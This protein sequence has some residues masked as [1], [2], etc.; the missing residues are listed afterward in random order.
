M[1]SIFRQQPKAFY[2][3]FMLEFWERF[4]FYSVNA[5]LAYFFV[6]QLGFSESVAFYTF[7]AFSALVYGLVALGGFVGDK[8]LGTKRTIV[9]GLIVLA[10]G[11]LSLSLATT[12]TV[13]V[14]LGIICV[15]N[16]LFKAN[17][18]SLLAKC[19]EKNDRRLH[20][21]FTLYYMAINIG[22]I[23]AISIAP[24][25]SEH[26]GWHAA[27]FLS[28]IG[29]SSAL[30]NYYVQRKTIAQY[31]FGADKLPVSLV[32]YGL[33]ILGVVG[34]CIASCFLLQHVQVTKKIL[35]AVI[36]VVL[37]M[38]GHYMYQEEGMR[39][40]KML[41]ALVLMVEAIVFFTLY[42]QMPTSINFFSIHH[43]RPYLFGL[44]VN[45]QTFQ[46]LNPIWIMIM[47]PVLAHIY[48]K[49][50]KANHPSSTAHKFAIGMSLCSLSF[51]VLYFPQFFADSQHMV[52][53]W[54]LIVSYFFQSTGE[55]LVSALGVAMVAE[56]VPRAISGFIMGMWF[57][58]SSIAGFTGAYLASLT[59][60]QNVEVG[61]SSLSV[62]G[63]VF[64][65]I[66]L[67]TLVISLLM[68]LIAPRLQRIATSH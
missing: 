15:G 67:A 12:E 13:F 64:L 55:L 24:N 1:S 46:V 4:G 27:F 5:I 7:G 42:Q 66:G 39:R 47:S 11:Y 26:F 25:V 48:M 35:L 14:A 16:G 30:L 65:E 40:K 36:V 31:Q 21:A 59:K 3:I 23:F 17:P 34:L 62:Y 54:W 53:S 33:V 45:P 49:L 56:L 51:V 2:L 18:S 44:P 20:G 22:S 41:V 28:F 32:R 63:H 52:S 61:A 10:I 68:F 38:Y 8:I 43:V 60:P 19:Y 58:T 57:L 37:C 9:L 6:H 29:L 50:Y